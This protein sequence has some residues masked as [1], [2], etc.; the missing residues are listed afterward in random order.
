MCNNELCSYPPV[1]ER[2]FSN[3]AIEGIV[4]LN[5]DLVEEICLSCPDAVIKA[6]NAGDFGFVSQGIF[7]KNRERIK[8]ELLARIFINNKSISPSVFI[9]IIE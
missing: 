5:S 7:N 6:L 3:M 4:R 9:P 2:Y 1:S 8:S